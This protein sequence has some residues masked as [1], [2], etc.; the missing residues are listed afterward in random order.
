MRHPLIV[1]IPCALLLACAKK[2]DSAA[3]SS[4]MAA[5]PAALTDAQVSGTWTGTAKLAGTDS[6]V[7]HWTQVCGSGT[8]MGTTTEMPR[9][10]IHA[11]YR[12]DADS[13][14]G[15]ST[16]YTDPV[17]KALIIDNWVARFSGSTVTGHGW[18]VLADKPDSV[19][20]RYTF[21]GMRQ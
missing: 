4:M 2:E 16:P 9:D 12:L 15:V 7:Q 14:I 11:T 18:A 1:L 10:T 17:A 19:V 20:M 8:C 5:A 6:V 3:D 21:D 13:T